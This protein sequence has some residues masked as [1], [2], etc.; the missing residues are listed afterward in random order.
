ME[1]ISFYIV[2]FYVLL[3]DS[4]RLLQQE[5]LQYVWRTVQ[6]LQRGQL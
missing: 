6:W 3:H 5:A 2:T 4:P 1:A